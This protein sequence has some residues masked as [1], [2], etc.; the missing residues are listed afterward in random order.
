MKTYNLIYDENVNLSS[1]LIDLKNK[2]CQIN[3]VLVELRVIN[4]KSENDSFSDINGIISVEEDFLIT[5]NAEFDTYWHLQRV[6]K[7]ELPLPSKPNFITDGINE[8]IYLIDS[9]VNFQCTELSNA[10]TKGNIKNLY[11]FNENF[12]DI[13]GHG[14]G[15]ASL[16]LGNRVGVS[17]GV[18]LKSIKIPFDQQMPLF[19]LL[20]AFNAVLED[21]LI[22]SNKVKIV[23]CSW[24]VPK[25]FTLDTKISELQDA[26]L[27]VVAAAGNQLDNADKYSPVGLNAVL[28]VGASDTFDRVVSWT[29]GEGT[30]W[31][32]EV[33][34]FAPGI[35]VMISDLRGDLIEVSG[36]SLSAAVTSAIVAQ[37]IHI[38]PDA[39]VNQIK[40]IIINYT[41]EDLLFRNEDVYQNTP[42]RLLI[43]PTLDN[44]LWSPPYGSTILVKQGN[45]TRVPISISQMTNYT[46]YYEDIIRENYKTI[47]SW[48]WVTLE[49]NEDGYELIIDATNIDVGKY[50][51][52]SLV[53]L[54]NKS[55]YI[56]MH[57]IGCYLNDE[58]DL[59]EINNEIYQI[60]DDENT[61]VIVTKVFCT[62]PSQCPKGT[63]CI[64]YQCQF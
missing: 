53:V 44:K 62:S 20:K 15:L 28:G 54:E 49:Q 48:E 39:N 5:A 17:P 36:T 59:S 11:S 33:D 29:P 1:F 13:D 43:A 23:N 31:G 61:I 57:T 24:T 55:S 12:D 9:G 50:V 42:N 52:H 47:K 25:S 21:H 35:D 2:N 3:E 37:I 30:N 38:N 40:N 46:I 7:K 63:F 26:G 41:A 16:I 56:G 64:N 14:T 6:S 58:S 34:F 32:P 45:V 18:C 19:E 60:I 8:I 27:I 51:I 22:T 10:I 4:L